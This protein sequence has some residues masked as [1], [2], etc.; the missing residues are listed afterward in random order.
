MTALTGHYASVADTRLYYETAG[1]PSD[2]PI[3]L[4]HT[5]GADSRQW[6]YVAPALA[7]QGYYAVVPDL[8]GHGKSYPSDWA[9][10]TTIREHAAATWSLV[11][12][13][14][15]SRP[16]VS[17]CSVGGNVTLD[18]AVTR[19]DALRCA[20]AFEG[21]ANTRGAATGRLS[22]PQACPGW[23]NVLEYSVVDSTG[24]Q[25]PEERRTEL[26]W[27]HHGSQAV[28]T[29]DLQGWADFDVRDRLADATCPVLVVR[30]EDDFYIQDDVFEETVDGL[31]DAEGIEL[32]DT[33]HYPMMERPERTTAVITDFLDENE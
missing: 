10:T 1:D 17:G 21:A 16:V 22:H 19:G 13:L 3:V 12:A 31:P 8:P 18:L 4:V 32:A 20:V 5:A 6:R 30:G 26:R 28:A 15:L 25:C 29:S 24:E 33:G 9:V 27:Q 7:E 14:D 2:Q 23:Q 11:E